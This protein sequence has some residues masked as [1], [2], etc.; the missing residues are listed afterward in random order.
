MNEPYATL[1]VRRTIRAT[2]EKL[3]AAWT[4][5]QQLVRWWGPEGVTCPAAEVDLRPG[6]SYRIANLMPDG[7]QLWISGEFELIEPPHRLIYTW[8]LELPSAGIERV[9]ILFEARG[10]GTEVIVTHERIGSA[11]ARTTHERGWQ[12]C[13]A[14]LA[15]FAEGL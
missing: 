7:T 13:L 4:D 14:G 10:A 11:A 3:F 5:P 1:V 8:R 6:G 15:R 12:Q 9:S 2:P